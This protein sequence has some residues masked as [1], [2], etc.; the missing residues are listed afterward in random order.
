M[1]NP[2]SKKR[3]AEDAS[4]ATSPGVTTRKKNAKTSHENS[5]PKSNESYNL[6]QKEQLLVIREKLIE[7]REGLLFP[8]Y[9]VYDC[10]GRNGLVYVNW[11]ENTADVRVPRWKYNPTQWLGSITQASYEEFIEQNNLNNKLVKFEDKQKYLQDL[12]EFEEKLKKKKQNRQDKHI[13]SSTEHFLQRFNGQKL[14]PISLYKDFVLDGWFEDGSANPSPPGYDYMNSDPITDEMLEKAY[15]GIVET[16][17]DSTE[18]VRYLVRDGD[19]GKII[20]D[21]LQEIFDHEERNNNLSTLD[22][23]KFFMYVRHGIPKPGGGFL[24]RGPRKLNRSEYDKTFCVTWF[25]ERMER[26]RIESSASSYIAEQNK[27]KPATGMLPQEAATQGKKRPAADANSR[28]AATRSKASYKNDNRSAEAIT[29]HH[30]RSDENANNGNP[31]ASSD[32]K[33]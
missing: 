19:K 4:A 20:L 29:Y 1:S 26:A 9:E 30:Q 13:T 25:K 17:T 7:D 5:S 8:S 14:P 2:P 27:K 24:V 12:K 18:Y 21:R 22:Q 31:N 32:G 23:E 15:K 6:R 3:C 28:E 16:Y 11:E 33:L 10:L